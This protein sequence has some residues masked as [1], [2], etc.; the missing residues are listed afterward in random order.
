MRH[1]ARTGA[2][3]GASTGLAVSGTLQCRRPSVELDVTYA[4][5]LPR[6]MQ[7]L[8]PSV[9]MYSPCCC[10]ALTTLSLSAGDGGSMPPGECLAG[11]IAHRRGRRRCTTCLL[12]VWRPAQPQ[13]R[14]HAMP[15]LIL[16]QQMDVADTTSSADC[17]LQNFPTRSCCGSAC[18][19]LRQASTPPRPYA[20]ASSDVA[21]PAEPV[22]ETLQKA[23]TYERKNGCSDSQVRAP[24]G[25]MHGS[26]C[27][28]ASLL[29]CAHC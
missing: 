2:L 12:D 6:L 16:W 28:A 9:R 5:L 26:A 25:R 14:Y 17:I 15:Q 27:A 21:T 10:L 29:P 23:I 1:W 11:V 4:L 3:I 19:L 18:S 20:A 24:A 7:R 8:L 22:S 13:V